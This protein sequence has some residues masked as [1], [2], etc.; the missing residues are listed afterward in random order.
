MVVFEQRSVGTVY[1]FHN[2]YFLSLN[3]LSQS[4]ATACTT[5]WT[6]AGKRLHTLPSHHHWVILVFLWSV[7]CTWLFMR[8]VLGTG[9]RVGTVHFSL[10]WN[11]STKQI[12]E[13]A[14][15]QPGVDVTLHMHAW[16]H[17]QLWGN[18][19]THDSTVSPNNEWISS[20]TFSWGML[21]KTKQTQNMRK[22]ERA[23][24]GESWL[25]SIWILTPCKQHR[26][27]YGWEP[28]TDTDR[29]CPS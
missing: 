9:R 21:A 17:A 27:T 25:I 20:F 28:E 4:T 12:T 8:M 18:G 2:K 14:A 26:V 16:Q 24:G 11:C 7:F 13:A 1:F 10:M 15:Q 6:R 3:P 23:G 22:R 29:K 19:C 5:V